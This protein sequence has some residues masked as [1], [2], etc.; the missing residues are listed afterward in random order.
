MYRLDNRVQEYAWGSRTAIAEL[1]GRPLPSPRP[2]AE[3]WLGAHPS[4]PSRAL[5]HGSWQSLL[6]IVAGAPREEL[7]AEVVSRFGS[8][9]PFLFKVLAAETP[10]SLQVHPDAEQAKTGFEAEERARVPLGAPERMYKD[11]SHKPELLCALGP[12]VLLCGFRRAADTARLFS[13]LGVEAL[14]ERASALVRAPGPE[15]LRHLCSWLFSVREPARSDL[16]LAV[17]AACARHVETGGEFARECGWAARIAAMY[18]GD[19]GVVIALLLNLVTLQAGQAIYLPAGNLHAYLGGVGLEIM[20]NS[21]NVIRGGLT[22]KHVNVPELLRIL[23]FAD[24]PIQPV[25][26]RGDGPEQIY[27]T[28]ASEFRL[29][30]ITLRDSVF[31][32]DKRQGAEILLCTQGSAS[33]S[34]ADGPA[35]ALPRGASVFVP[36]S[37]GAYAVS[38]AGTVFRATVGAL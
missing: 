27:E 38:G 5:R 32:A 24:G 36:A 10:L 34:P 35:T 12:F 16:V 37:A 28:P 14:S 22:P 6:E 25:L 33:A 13:A 11:R 15:G 30:C 9:L 23:S 19:I 4:A 31:H 29:S 1:L 2:E 20:A 26:P 17:L 8:A 18:P 21:D 7:G 3:L